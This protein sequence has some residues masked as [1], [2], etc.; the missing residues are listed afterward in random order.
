MVTMP[1]HHIIVGTIGL[2]ILAIGAA[3]PVERTTEP[4]LSRKNIFF[5]IGNIFMF[6]Y[7]LM[8]YFEGGSIFFILLQTLIIVSTILMFLKTDD[9]LDAA[10]LA[11]IGAALTTYA[12][13]LFQDFTTVIFVL[14][15]VILGIGFAFDMLSMWRQVALTAG[16]VLIAI[17][18]LIE[19]NQIF[20]WLNVVFAAFSGFHALRMKMAQNRQK[21]LN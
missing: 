6:G 11:C 7:S 1:H 2:L 10:I 12:L 5:A 14:G 15:L 16:S 8:N 13:F 18:S 19:G 17:F 9:K 3:W 20:L 21:P 4:M